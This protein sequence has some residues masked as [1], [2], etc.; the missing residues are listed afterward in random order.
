MAEP[1]PP[2]PPPE[3]HT[4]VFPPQPKSGLLD[5]AKASALGAATGAVAALYNQ[6]LGVQARAKAMTPEEKQAWTERGLTGLSLAASVGQIVGGKKVKAASAVTNVALQHR[7][8]S[9]SSSAGA[10]AAAPETQLVEVVATENG[11]SP[12]LVVVDGREYTV[13]VPAGVAKG[14]AFRFEVEVPPVPVAT[15]MATPVAPAAGGYGGAAQAPPPPPPSG[16][17]PAS[18]FQTAI[19]DAKAVASAAR[20]TQQVAKEVRRDA[21]RPL[22]ARSGPLRSTPAPR[23]R[24]R[25]GPRRRSRTPRVVASHL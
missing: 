14:Q 22:R 2:P 19:N 21:P 18:G 7:G 9:S 1:P 23:H 5:K 12:M 16:S 25:S 6:G 10:A 8:A 11:G 3:G 24:V 15:A 13:V 20:T 4:G 17:G